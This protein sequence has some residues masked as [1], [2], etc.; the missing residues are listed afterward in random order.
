[1]IDKKLKEKFWSLVDKKTPYGPKGKCWKWIGGYHKDSTEKERLR[2]QLWGVSSVYQLAYEIQCGPLPTD[3]GVKVFHSCN[4]PGCVRG[5]HLFTA[6][7]RKGLK[8]LQDAGLIPVDRF[9]NA[10]TRRFITLSPIQ[11][12]KL[13]GLRS[14]KG[15]TM[16][17]LQETV[18]I[19]KGLYSKFEKGTRGIAYDKFQAIL[20][21]IETDEK[22]LNIKEDQISVR[23]D[24][25]S[26]GLMEGQ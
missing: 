5:S 8:T 18:E 25:A 10:P 1:M 26:L 19:D 9:A 22:A 3:P 11:G 12:E 4:M 13:R 20:V 23:R 16:G 17:L 15:V 14:D 7:Q 6:T 2:P 21:K 24:L